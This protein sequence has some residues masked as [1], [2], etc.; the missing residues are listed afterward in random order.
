LL[1]EIRVKGTT[2]LNVLAA[3]HKVEGDRASDLLRK[4]D[5]ELST[6]IQTRSIIAAGWYPVAWHRRLLG[7]VVG[8]GG[9]IELSEVV[10]T[11]TRDSMSSIHRALVKMLSPESLLR[12]SSRIF[13]SFFEGTLAVRSETP[14]IVRIDWHRCVGFDRTCWQAQVLTVDELVTMTGSRVRGRA[15]LAGGGDG[16]AD[17][18]LELRWTS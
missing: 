17:M 1:S 13:S 9:M 16:D 8:R 3:I 2:L 10:R 6:A 11:S 4:V 14:G 15:V 12:Q 5:G 18:A 7:E